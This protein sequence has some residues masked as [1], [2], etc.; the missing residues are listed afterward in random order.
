M[1]QVQV[2]F[3]LLFVF[4]CLFFFL[5]CLIRWCVEMARNDA[6]EA[7]RLTRVLT[8]NFC[9]KLLQTKEFYRCLTKF[10]LQNER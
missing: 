4:F 8:V 10:Q 5:F 9:D 1:L 6:S 2:S 7:V 3:V